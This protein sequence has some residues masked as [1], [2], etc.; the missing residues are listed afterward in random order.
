MMS[1][2]T[3][4]GHPEAGRYEIRIRGHLDARWA[5]WFDG[6]S[7]TNASNGTTVI[8][9]PVLD[10]GISDLELASRRRRTALTCDT[11]S[12]AADRGA[13]GIAPSGA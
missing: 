3:S 11:R 4:G 1:E 9:G 13:E 6:M 8:S 12:R 5:A 10:Q 2:T 7:L